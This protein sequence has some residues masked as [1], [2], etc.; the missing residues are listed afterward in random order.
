MIQIKKYYGKRRGNK[1]F[2]KAAEIKKKEF[3]FDIFQETLNA[4]ELKN[5]S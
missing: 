5:K 4:L 2:I 1:N 3:K